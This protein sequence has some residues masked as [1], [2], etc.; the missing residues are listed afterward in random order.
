MDILGTRD[1]WESIVEQDELLQL[2]KARRATWGPASKG[3]TTPYTSNLRTQYCESAAA[4]VPRISTTSE[5][6]SCTSCNCEAL[7]RCSLSSLSRTIN[8]RHSFTSMVKSRNL[9]DGSL[10]KPNPLRLANVKRWDPQ[11]QSMNSWDGLRHVRYEI[12]L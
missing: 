4:V 11:T 10:T 6:L 8:Y 1:F 5:E 7:D 3:T 12:S 2:N 9:G